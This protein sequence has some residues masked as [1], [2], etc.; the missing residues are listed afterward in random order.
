MSIVAISDLF[1]RVQRPDS[2]SALC[3]L[4]ISLGCVKPIH[5]RRTSKSSALAWRLLG[6]HDHQVAALRSGHAALNHQQILVLVHAQHSQVPLRHT[7]ITHVARHTHSLKHSR[8]EG[9]GSDGTGNLKHRTVRLWTTAKMMALHD[10]LKPASL[11]DSYDVDK[12]LAIENFHQHTI[13]HFDRT[14]FD[15]FDRSFDPKRHFT[16][17]L[18]RRKIVLRE[19]TLCRLGEP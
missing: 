6:L 15:P 3:F 4:R 12:A 19:M 7:G 11:A 16:H 13:A 17:E 9:R 2:P 14:V 5:R 10:A 8:R 18:H 1:A